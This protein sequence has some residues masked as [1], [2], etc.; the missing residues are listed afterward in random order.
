MDFVR[1][2]FGTNEPLPVEHFFSHFLA[3]TNQS[4]LTQF[5]NENMSFSKTVQRQQN[6]KKD[7]LPASQYTFGPSYFVRALVIYL[8]EV[9]RLPCDRFAPSSNDLIA[10]VVFTPIFQVCPSSSIN[11]VSIVT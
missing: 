3:G 2:N 5:F 10:N 1:S 6:K 11:L 7:Y 4:F 8:L 9:P